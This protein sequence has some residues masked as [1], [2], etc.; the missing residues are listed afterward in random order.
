M[1]GDIGLERKQLKQPLAEGVKG[2]DLEAARRLDRAGEQLPGEG[3]R[4][5]PGPA[6]PG[7][8][9]SLSQRLVVEARP[10][11]ELLEDAARHIG[12]GGLGEGKAED[13]RRLRPGEQQPQHALRQNV[14]LAAAGVGGNPGRGGRIGG[15]R[16][17]PPQQIGD[18]EPPPHQASPAGVSPAPPASDHSLTRARWS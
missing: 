1:G 2:L 17:M 9:D 5:R 11:G 3:E 14:R 7:F 6:G 12:G 15:E 10:P 8:D 18:F 16:L 13:L 4:R